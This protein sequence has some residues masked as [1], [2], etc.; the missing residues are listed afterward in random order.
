VHLREF[1]IGQC[2]AVNLQEVGL[3]NAN[4]DELFDCSFDAPEPTTC[5]AKVEVEQRC[6]GNAKVAKQSP[7]MLYMAA[8]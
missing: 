4:L 3:W 8:T 6:I 5:T 1:G 2:S 7:E